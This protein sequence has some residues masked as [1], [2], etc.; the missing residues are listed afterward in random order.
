MRSER[1]LAFLLLLPALI[2]LVGL[3]GYP[4]FY[5]VWLSLTDK[6]IG[7]R[8]DFVW[9]KNFVRLWGDATFRESVRNTAIFTVVSV[10]VK[11]V[12]GLALATLL[13]LPLRGKKVARALLLLPWAVPVVVAALAWRWIFD[14]LTGVLNY[15]LL[16]THLID[17][18]IAFLGDI[19]YALAAVIAVNIWRGVPFFTINLLAGLQGIPREQYE[20]ADVDGAGAW[21]KFT[22]ITLPSLRYVLMVTIML[23]T[24]WTF[25]EFQQIWVMTAGGPA[26]STEVISTFAYYLGIKSMRL[27]QGSAVSV[28]FLPVMILI[29]ILVSRYLEKEES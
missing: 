19:H 20:A 1:R 21:R 4:F 9:F 16:S 11:T 26:H 24:I 14:D 10:A 12:L 22:R 29:I 18:K 8:W 28:F 5:S 17:Q 7:R 27:G 15:L 25:N 2:I 23:S 3:V 13:N 6:M